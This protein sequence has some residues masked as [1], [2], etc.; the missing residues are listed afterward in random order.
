MSENCVICLDELK[1]D[2][3]KLECDHSFH[4]ICIDESISKGNFTCPLCRNIIIEE[5]KEEEEDHPYD[6]YSLTFYNRCYHEINVIERYC[7]FHYRDDPHRY[8]Y[9]CLDDPYNIFESVELLNI[10]RDVEV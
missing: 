2:V 7:E 10:F 8:I 3:C 9:H 6:E 5:E 1:S 4:Q